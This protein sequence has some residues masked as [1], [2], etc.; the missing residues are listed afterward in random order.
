[1]IVEDIVAGKRN[2]MCITLSSCITL[3]HTQDGTRLVVK[4]IVVDVGMVATV[5]DL[6][7]VCMEK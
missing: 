2:S 1:M 5:R 3:F 6:M 7:Y 4:S